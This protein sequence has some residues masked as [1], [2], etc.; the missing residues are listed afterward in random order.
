MAVNIPAID[1]SIDAP[2]IFEVRADRPVA[3][4]TVRL[5]LSNTSDH[6]IVLHSAA[7][8]AELFWHLLDDGDREVTRKDAARTVPVA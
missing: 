6:S 7:K 4:L 5:T 8:G 3:K 2:S 1:A